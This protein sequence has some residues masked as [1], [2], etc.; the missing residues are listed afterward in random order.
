MNCETA[1]TKPKQTLG[2]T[3][4]KTKSPEVGPAPDVSLEPSSSDLIVAMFTGRDSGQ[5]GAT[6]SA[7]KQ[8]SCVFAC[9]WT[10]AWK[11]WGCR[12][13]FVP[14][15]VRRHGAEPTL[16]FLPQFPHCQ[17]SFQCLLMKAA[18]TDHYPAMK[19]FWLHCMVARTLGDGMRRMGGF[20]VQSCKSFYM[21]SSQL[22]LEAEAG[23]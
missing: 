22:T 19:P 23:C 2:N 21:P 9:K 4:L 8:L 18:W 3:S 10:L 16:N 11:M 13:L 7:D 5:M 6:E 14:P 1:E 12:G 17:T 20:D 15:S